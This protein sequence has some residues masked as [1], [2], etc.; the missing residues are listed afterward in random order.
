MESAIAFFFIDS[1]ASN[2][3]IVDKLM[4]IFIKNNVFGKNSLS[5][6]TSISSGFLEASWLHFGK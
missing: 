4:N 6:L 1:M 3:I 2:T 5:R